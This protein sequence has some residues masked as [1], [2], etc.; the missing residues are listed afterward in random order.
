MNKNK[1]LLIL[2]A[3]NF[4]TNS[5]IS[6]L[7]KLCDKG[8]IEIDIMVFTQNTPED[9]LKLIRDNYKGKINIIYG[10]DALASIDMDVKL[11]INKLISEIKTRL[12]YIALETGGENWAKKFDYLWWKTSLSEKNSPSEPYWFELFK[13]VSISNQI[14]SNNYTNYIVVCDDNLKELINQIKT[15]SKIQFIDSLNNKK[16]FRFHRFILARFLG[17]ICLLVSTILAKIYSNIIELLNKKTI[18]NKHPILLYTWF[19]RVWT[20]KS[21]TL[22]DMYLANLPDQIKRKYKN[23]YTLIL[24]I[25][26]KTNFLSP[27]TYIR[28]LAVL[29]KSNFIIKN[30]IILESFGSLKNIIYKYLNLSDILEFKKMSQH[31]KYKSVYLWHG[32]DLYKYFH[33]MN[34]KSV[35]VHWP[36]LEILSENSKLVTNKL[37]PSAVL[38]YCY[39]FT[40]G[41]SI[42]QGTRNS[43]KSIPIIGMQHGPI[44]NMKLLYTFDI[45]EVANHPEYNNPSPYP[46][47][48]SVDGEIAKNILKQNN[49]PD[50]RIAVTGP[51]R[52]DDVW[53]QINLK[54]TQTFGKKIKV[55]IAPGLHDTNYVLSLSLPALLSNPNLEIIIKLHPKVSNKKFQSLINRYHHSEQNKTLGKINISTELNIYKLMQKSDIFIT[56]YSSTSV[57]ALMFN[58]PIILLIPNHIPDMSIYHKN[59][60]EVLKASSISQLKKHVEKIINNKDYCKS[61]SKNLSIMLQKT[62]GEVDYK[63]TQRLAELCN[64]MTL[65][66]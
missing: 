37:N 36:H 41:K 61:Y 8:L 11:N 40:Y 4:S 44:T 30:S 54:N 55:L 39:E 51:A 14:K 27:I 45:N 49:I 58:L 29:Y 12:N 43:N 38:L 31:S 21:G 18:N 57:E 1:N 34:W 66:K 60:V 52:F 10:S 62:F 56:T 2:S 46:D 33:K 63:S 47:I 7:K 53:K 35:L 65:T 50:S 64:K 22:Q 5:L 48:F 59:D 32:F 19:P 15:S 6:S 9:M 13:I 20:N 42:T 23:N 3:D 26:D 16:L 24:R 17:L 28:R 25:Y